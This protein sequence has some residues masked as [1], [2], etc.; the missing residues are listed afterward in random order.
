MPIRS[1]QDLSPCCSGQP[2]VEYDCG[3]KMRCQARTR[4]G[5][6]CRNNAISGTSFCYISTHG[7]IR[8]TPGQ[9]VANFVKNKWV[10]LTLDL[11][12]VTRVK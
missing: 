6:K 11:I 1:P 10:V 2:V 8:K 3:L 9:R 7:H 5:D 4:S 12:T